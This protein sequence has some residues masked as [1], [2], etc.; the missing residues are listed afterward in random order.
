MSIIWVPVY[1][2]LLVC[3]QG[4][5]EFLDRCFAEEYELQNSKFRS[6]LQVLIVPYRKADTQN[7][8]LYSRS[9]PVRRLSL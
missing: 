4:I 5:A 9:S 6:R 8:L 1:Y 7:D 2:K 3:Y